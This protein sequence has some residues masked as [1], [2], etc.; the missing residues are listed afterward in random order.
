MT[1]DRSTAA[2][3]VWMRDLVP[4]HHLHR[5]Y[6]SLPDRMCESGRSL[7]ERAVFFEVPD[8]AR[9]WEHLEG[10]LRTVW[11][12]DTTDWCEDGAAYNVRSARELFEENS[13]IAPLLRNQNDLRLFESAWGGRD[14]IGPEHIHYSRA[15][16]VDL[17]VTP[18]VAARLTAAMVEIERLYAVQSGGAA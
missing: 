14:G 10:L 9:A 15:C 7:Q 13:S 3:L 16:D 5:A 2:A 12:E 18:R 6:V 17:F 11:C 1:A 4:L 8:G